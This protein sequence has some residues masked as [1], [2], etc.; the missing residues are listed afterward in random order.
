MHIRTQRALVTKAVNLDREIAEKTEI[1][2]DLKQQLVKEATT[3][4]DEYLI[5]FPDGGKSIAF[6]GNDGCIARI[7]FPKPTLNDTV[8]GEGKKIE[9]IRAYA[10]P[11]FHRLF[12]QAPKYKLTKDFRKVTRELL[13]SKSARALIKLCTSKSAARVAFETKE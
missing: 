13:Y 11:H 9:K 6:A 8:S 5:T 12:S 4:P 3:R 10:G 7:T 1:L 2:K